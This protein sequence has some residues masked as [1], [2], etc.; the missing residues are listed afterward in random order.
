MEVN[1]CFSAYSVWDLVFFTNFAIADRK[2]EVRSG[3]ERRDA[4]ILESVYLRSF[5]TIGNLVNFYIHPQLCWLAAIFSDCSVLIVYFERRWS[6]AGA[7]EFEIIVIRYRFLT[8]LICFFSLNLYP[9]NSII[10]SL[11]PTSMMCSLY[12]AWRDVCYFGDMPKTV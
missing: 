1:I 7:N 9:I 12:T 2:A 8:A 6:Q 3:F 4:D 11:K 5:L 10:D